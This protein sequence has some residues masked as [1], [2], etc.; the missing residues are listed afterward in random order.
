[1]TGAATSDPKIDYAVADGIACLTISQPARMNAMTFDMWRQ[2]TA[3]VADAERD[4]AVRV[5]VL[6]GDGERAFCAG[7][8][9]SEFGEKRTGEAAVRAYDSVV[10]K[11]NRAVQQAAKPTVALIRGV[12]FG[13]GFGLAL[14]CDV[15]LAADG[16]RFRV[17]AA[18]LGLGYGFEDVQMM[19]QRIGASAAADVLLSARILDAAEA[20][21]LSVVQRRWPAA[22]F[23]G[24][25]AG[26]VGQ[27]AANAPLTIRAIKR[28]LIEISRPEAARDAGAIKALVEACS[29]SEDYREG[30][31]AFRESRPPVFRGR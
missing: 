20:E 16:A 11:A 26:Y 9:I 29:R 14:A 4:P 31:A 12:C 5:I 3:R 30:Q 10:A 15:R 17:P 28:A 6:A 18:R 22:E 8:D 24:S 13:G 19:V 23:A 25:A 27:I 2:V 7:A 1:M 21:R